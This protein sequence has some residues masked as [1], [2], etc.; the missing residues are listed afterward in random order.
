MS[1]ES[2]ADLAACSIDAVGWNARNRVALEYREFETRLRTDLARWRRDRTHKPVDVPPAAL[3]EGSPLDVE[4]AL[5]RLR[6]DFIEGISPDHHFDLEALI[7]FFLKLQI[8]HRLGTFDRE[9]GLEVY[10][11][12]C[13]ATSEGT[14]R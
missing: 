8:L 9:K 11:S 6:W 13:E 7:L 1:P 4:R 2:Q 5:L 10:H 12:L 14:D 3:T